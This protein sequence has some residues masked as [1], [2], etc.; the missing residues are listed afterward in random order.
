MK[1][2]AVV[3]IILLPFSANTWAAE[4]LPIELT[5][6]IGQY[7]VYLHITGSPETT[8]YQNH[9]SNI[10][11]FGRW[12]RYEESPDRVEVRDVVV[13]LNTIYIDIGRL[14]GG[15]DFYINR[16][17]GGVYLID[18]SAYRSQGRKTA[19]GHCTEGF[20]EYENNL[21]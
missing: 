10:D 7:I 15:A 19:T 2:L 1:S 13:R 17:T 20:K 6:E 18:S 8:W 14:S 21:F 11:I 9:S 12:F 3:A 4:E 5:C 16:L